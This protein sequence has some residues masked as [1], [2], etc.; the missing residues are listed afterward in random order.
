MAGEILFGPRR[1]TVP[2]PALQVVTRLA[3]Q[4][5]AAG[6]GWFG[7]GPERAIERCVHCDQRS[8]ACASRTNKYSRDD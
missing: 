7:E 2:D 4:R 5:L 8:V 6:R 1:L 3:Q